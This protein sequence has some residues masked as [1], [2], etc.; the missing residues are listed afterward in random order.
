ML[1]TEGGAG[2]QVLKGLQGARLLEE[3]LALDLK[4]KTS[5]TRVGE[6]RENHAQKA[7]SC[8]RHARDGNQA[9]MTT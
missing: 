8:A 2:E 1:E 5:T 4:R 7:A 3:E 9:R 6:G